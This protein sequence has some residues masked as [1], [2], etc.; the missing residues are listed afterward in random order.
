M[1]D[2]TVPYEPRSALTE[3]LLKHARKS[4]QEVAQITGLDVRLVA[5]KYAKLFED[6]GWMTDRQEERLLIIELGDLLAD[7]KDR[8][9]NAE[10]KDYASI[11]KIVLSGL[12]LMANRFDNRKK[13]VEEDINLIT[14]ANARL[15]GSA[16]EI[17][18]ME[19]AEGVM[20]LTNDI[21]FEDVMS[22]ARSGL[23]KAKTMLEANVNI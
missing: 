20:A 16:Y 2:A 3:K 18:V 21:S 4:L 23:D 10:D 7:A 8:L 15:F 11:A 22:L 13:L 5:E 17:A 14:Q 12:T 19:I 1:T 6:R 9:E